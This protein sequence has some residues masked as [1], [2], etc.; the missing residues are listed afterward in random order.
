ML[1]SRYQP[2]K[3]RKKA[4]NAWGQLEA[5]C[6]KV[7]AALYE[8]RDKISARRYRRRLEQALAQLPEND[9][10]ILR[11]EGIALLHELR[12]ENALAIPH[13]ERE[14][15]LMKR[16]HESVKRSVK[17]G[18]Y[19]AETGHSILAGRDANVLKE[20]RAI[21]QSLQQQAEKEPRN[22]RT[23]PCC[24]SRRKTIGQKTRMGTKREPQ[25]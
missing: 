11:E 22:L 7:H 14:I 10:A 4:G 1:Q 17:N 8:R 24:S 16:L 23:A 13:R 20:R 12:S 21:L 2:A 6:R 3:R 19:E 25:S 15:Q 18:D 9:I 5:I